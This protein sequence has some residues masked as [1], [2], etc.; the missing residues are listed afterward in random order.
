MGH[1]I[2]AETGAAFTAC[3][4]LKSFVRRKSKVGKTTLS[5]SSVFREGK[6]KR[7]KKKK[8]I[9]FPRSTAKKNAKQKNQNKSRQEQSVFC[10]CR[11]FCVYNELV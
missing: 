3:I 6:K 5:G 4:V 8:K 2:G 7:A 11:L 9:F 10:G 1:T